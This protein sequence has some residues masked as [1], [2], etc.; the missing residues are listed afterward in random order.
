MVGVLKYRIHIS[1][2]DLGYAVQGSRAWCSGVRVENFPES[3]GGA[4]DQVVLH[5]KSCRKT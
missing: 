4:W 5:H 3:L 1:V 2:L